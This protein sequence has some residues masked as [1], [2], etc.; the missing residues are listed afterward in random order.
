MDVTLP[1]SLVDIAADHVRSAILS[2]RLR[3]GDPLRVRE[4]QEQLGFSH[5]P[6]R[7]AIRQLEA[8][9]LVVAPPRRT[10]VV[11]GVSLDEFTAIYELRC[12]IE[13][14]TIRAARRAASKEDVARVRNAFAAYERVAA[15]PSSPE[16]WKRH[17]E[18]HWALIAAGANPWTRR[19]LDP[20][21][22]GAERFVRLFV[23]TYASAEQTLDLH[24]Q[25]LDAYVAGDP[26]AL[27]D[28][29]EEH[30]AE[31]ERGVRQ[32][33]VTLE[34]G[35]APATRPRRRARGR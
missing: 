18:F 1:G 3:P 10:P 8:E 22:R 21:W 30:F 11:A 5:I 32:R 27:A 9:G 7:E 20:L 4:L 29:L 19:V 13:L 6:I 31:T 28:A 16:Y 34:N 26:D 17:E 33:F 14:P 15:E 12:M 35:T 2:G 25:L 24:R 23:Q